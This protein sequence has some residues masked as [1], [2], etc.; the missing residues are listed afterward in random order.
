M[1]GPVGSTNSFK[2]IQGLQL[3]VQDHDALGMCRDPL[4]TLALGVKMGKI[5]WK[6]EKSKVWPVKP[7]SSLWA[8][9]SYA[10]FF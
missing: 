8:V 10:V 2:G 6:M 4:R 1:Q 3:G 5:V 9:S 7:R